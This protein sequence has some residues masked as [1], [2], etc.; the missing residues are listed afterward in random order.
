VAEVIR[1]NAALAI[2]ERLVDAYEE[3]KA[4]LESR[5]TSHP[6]LVVHI[7]G[8]ERA[9]HAG[10]FSKRRLLRRILPTLYPDDRVAL[11]QLRRQ[12]GSP[13]ETFLAGPLRGR[14][15][16]S[17]KVALLSTAPLFAGLSRRQLAHIARLVD[18]IHRDAGE[19]LT[20]EG[21]SGDEFFI[22]VEGGVDVRKAGRRVGTL[23]PNQCFGEMSLLDDQPR[24]ATVTTTSPT[25]LAVIH[26]D[27]FARILKT[28]PAIMRALLTTLSER[29]R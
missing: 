13:T 6:T 8:V 20:E 2:D 25:T 18:E 19:V 26:R 21:D 29:L 7:D 9:R 28:T 11:A 10:S 5:A 22:V 14:I 27:D 15:R 24:S 3:S 23:G 1:E 16:Q 12:L 4:V 17:E